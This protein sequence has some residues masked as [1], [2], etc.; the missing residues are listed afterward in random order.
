VRRAETVSR[1][2]AATVA[3]RVDRERD[4]AHEEQFRQ[5]FQRYYRPVYLLFANRGFTGE[6]C[7]DLTQETFLRVVKGIGQLRSDAT[8]ECW[9]LRIAT[10][11]WKN[12]LRRR[13]AKMR[14]AKEISLDHEIERGTPVAAGRD[15]Q[16]R[17]DRPLEDLLVREQALL[18]RRALNELPAQMRRC[19]LMRIDQ[20]MKYREIA[21]VMQLSVE[22]VKSQI[23]QARKRLRAALRGASSGD[24]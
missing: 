23:S 8:L 11:V 9:V 4:P 1:G 14:E 16:A 15:V 22:T 13:S 17:I 6:E 24:A 7:L 3:G 18:I 5:V 21:A 2:D 20:E 19:I 10:N 12:E